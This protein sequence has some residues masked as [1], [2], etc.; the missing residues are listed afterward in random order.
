[1]TWNRTH[2][3]DFTAVFGFANAISESI[4]HQSQE[5]A[6]EVEKNV[7]QLQD[8]LAFDDEEKREQ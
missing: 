7:N 8:R 1:M 6:A 4:F 2:E 3:P 5:S